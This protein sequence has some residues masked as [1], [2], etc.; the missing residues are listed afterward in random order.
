[1]VPL[2]LIFC[3]GVSC[4]GFP[5]KSPLGI[6]DLVKGLLPLISIV[7]EGERK[8]IFFPFFYITLVEDGT[9]SNPGGGGGEKS[10]CGEGHTSSSAS[11]TYLLVSETGALPFLFLLDPCFST[12][13]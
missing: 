7:G 13:R 11:L 5:L 4:K 8:R 12:G 10:L 6:D 3:T 1:L 2:P 9:S